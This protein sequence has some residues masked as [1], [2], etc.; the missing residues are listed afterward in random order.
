MAQAKAGPSKTV[1]G[2]TWWWCPD[3][4]YKGNGGYDGLYVTHK[5]GKE[6]DE[7]VE[8]RD[9]KKA[10][11]NGG[12]STDPSKSNGASEKPQLKLSQSIKQALT[13][14]AGL[15]AKEANALCTKIL[16][17]SGQEN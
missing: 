13:S 11:K 6:H 14:S 2:K 10:K 9:A 4:V 8:R 7:W 16:K 17:E 1:D 12:G 3:H 5:P 15:S